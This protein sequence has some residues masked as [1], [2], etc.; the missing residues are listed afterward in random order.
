[1]FLPYGDMWEYFPHTH[2]WTQR[3]T[4]GG[5]GTRIG[6]AIIIVEDKMYLHAGLD[7]F[8]QSH[9]DLWVLDL[10]T[11]VWTQLIPDG[12]GNIPQGRYLHKAEQRGDFI[13]IFSGNVN[14]IGGELGVQWGDTWRYSISSNTW[15]E[16]TT[17]ST[18]PTRVHGGSALT[19]EAFFVYLGDTNDDADE[20][21]TREESAG[22]FPT[23]R[24]DV[25]LLHGRH[26]GWVPDVQL[27]NAPK[28]KRF[29]YV[30][31]GHEVYVWGGFDFVCSPILCSGPGLDI[32]GNPTNGTHCYNPATS[33]AIWNPNMYRLDIRDVTEFVLN[34]DDNDDD[35]DDD[36]NRRRVNPFSARAT[37]PQA[38]QQQPA[39][40]RSEPRMNERE[41]ALS[42]LNPAQRALLGRW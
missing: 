10:K 2:T 40:I 26:Q 18:V 39:P 16:I 24:M 37:A 19:S 21:K 14:P 8:F 42:A 4:T 34:G 13:Y 41:Q 3:Y 31:D 11:N 32:F 7:G 28:L 29:G 23:R 9:E 27:D 30:Q 22:Q 20:C 1:V 15:S 17:P 36:D 35:F 33:Y 25:Y 12:A 38:Q 6:S 5:P